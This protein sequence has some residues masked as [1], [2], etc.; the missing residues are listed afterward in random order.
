MASLWV[1]VYDRKGGFLACVILN[2]CFSPGLIDL[3]WFHLG[4]LVSAVALLW[5]FF[6]LVPCY[7]L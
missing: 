4:H 7:A 1:H 5:L 3:I 2:A 6:S